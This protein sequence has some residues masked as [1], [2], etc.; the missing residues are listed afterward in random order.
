MILGG[1]KE[2]REPPV[3]R[4]KAMMRSGMSE[5]DIVRQLK[6]EGYSFGEIEK[7]L[8]AV[9]KAGAA[10][11]PPGAE[12]GLPP[13]PVAGPAVPVAAPAAAPLAAPA[14]LPPA[15]AAAPLP[16]YAPYQ[17]APEYP[18]EPAYAPEEELQPEVIMEE[19]IES[20]AEEKFEKFSADIARLESELEKLRAELGVVRERAEVKPAPEIP[21][22]LSDRL[23]AL[24]VRIGGLEKAFK[25]LL[26]QISEN[27][28]AISKLIAEKRRQPAP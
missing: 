18:A 5:K 15:P 26:P 11:L 27:I 22:E 19:L 23:D 8:M 16:E 6:A 1:K 25:Q 3:D 20:V 28:G 12:L 13:K 10:P 9:V 24:D 17:P 7:A 14:E 4:V 21:K 2:A